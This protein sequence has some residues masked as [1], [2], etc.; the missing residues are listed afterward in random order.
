M[1][2]IFWLAAA[3]TV[4]GTGCARSEAVPDP[5][6]IRSENAAASKE[7]ARL[8]ATRRKLR[9]DLDKLRPRGT[10][11]VVDTYRNRIRLYRGGK[12]VVEDDCSTGSNASLVD[13]LSGH[14]W[15]FRTPRGR[16]SILGGAVS[17]PVW[18]RPDWAF[19]EEGDRPPADARERAEPDVLG[20]FALPIGD[21]YFIHGTLYTR[22]L[23]Y[24]ATHGCVRVGDATL[25]TIV[26]TARPGTPV[27]LF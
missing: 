15:T 7:I 23:G 12:L 14:E 6:T 5:A 4:L 25:E 9:A 26:K 21:G 1:K 19:I 20:K 8:A 10:Y 11:V 24:P 3:M 22:L 16:R 27:Y 17:D 13:S 18:I 2:A